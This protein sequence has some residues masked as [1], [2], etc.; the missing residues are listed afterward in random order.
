MPPLK[1]TLARR[2]HLEIPFPT[3]PRHSLT[4]EFLTGIVNRNLAK[5]SDN[6]KFA[7]LIVAQL[8][9]N[10]HL[11]CGLGFCNIAVCVH[12]NCKD[13]PSE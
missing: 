6:M 2:L 5:V 1:L 12:L 9:K 3:P 7:A 11:E 8:S 13:L 4:V 10:L